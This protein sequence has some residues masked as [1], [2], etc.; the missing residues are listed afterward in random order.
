MQLIN[1]G[2]LKVS[3]LVFKSM[4]LKAKYRARNGAKP[5]IIPA[6]IPSAKSS[7][8]KNI[9]INIDEMAI[10]I[11]PLLANIR[12]SNSLRPAGKNIQE[13]PSE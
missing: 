5:L 12:V 10:P 13:I 1:F 2:P 6:P 11:A 7:K 9:L 8:K 4:P 3:K